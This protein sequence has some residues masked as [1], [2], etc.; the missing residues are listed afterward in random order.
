MTG[1]PSSKRYES[2][3]ASRGLYDGSASDG[4][5]NT[6]SLA[7]SPP[8]DPQ[9]FKLRGGTYTLLVL[10]VVDLKQSSFYPWLAQKTSQAPNFYRHAPIALDLEGVPE[11]EEPDFREII[12]K[13]REHKLVAV[14]VQNGTEEQSDSAAEAG[15]SVFPMWRASKP[16]E[17]APQK[18]PEPKREPEPKPEPEPEPARQKSQERS[19]KLVTQ[20]IR[21]GR[22]IY[23]QNSDLVVL[24]TASA[25]S[26]LL[27]DGHIHVYGAIRGRALAGVGGD[28]SARIF[29]DC[30]QAEL[31]SVAGHWLVRE[32][33]DEKLIGRAVQ[34]YLKGDLLVIEP[35][36]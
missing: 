36:R 18:R 10:N 32:D 24:S 2:L 14:G 4:E 25:G 19:S 1:S 31:V 23:A 9:S 26:E 34:I 17:S 8:P 13:L 28:T 21:S 35:M 15:L 5:E 20:P 7:P 29:C 6:D 33:M 11:D 30:M 16:L 22:Q 3:I 12:A 27:A